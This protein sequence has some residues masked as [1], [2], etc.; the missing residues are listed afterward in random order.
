MELNK[1]I[2]IG[3]LVFEFCVLTNIPIFS[4]YNT[5][6]LKS[7]TTSKATSY[8]GLILTIMEQTMKYSVILQRLEHGL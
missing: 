2:V 7:L 5:I 4:V 3:L 1:K 6:K 8:Y